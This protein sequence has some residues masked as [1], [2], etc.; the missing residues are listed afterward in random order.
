MDE[1]ATSGGIGGKRLVVND[2]GAT[3]TTKRGPQDFPLSD[4]TGLEFE[5]GGRMAGGYLLIRTAATPAQVPA[6]SKWSNVEGLIEFLPTNRAGI[7]HAA[8]ELATL[9]GVSVPGLPDAR[10]LPASGIER[11]DEKSRA[12]AV[13]RG[14][15]V[16][17]ALYVDSVLY[18]E[19]Q[20]TIVVR[21]HV[22][23]LHDHGK[24]VS[25]LRTGKGVE[26]IPIARI[27]SVE[28]KK[29]GPLFEALVIYTSGNTIQYVSGGP[30][31]A[32]LRK[33]ISDLVN[34]Q[35]APKPA[36]PTPGPPA[37]P[38]PMAQLKQL[39]ELHAQGILT[40][41]EFAAKKTDLLGRL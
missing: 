6:R 10:P 27:S 37:A 33:I 28:T 3:I 20:T 36:S 38:D 19:R 40:D 9:L 23:E 39:A 41:A 24:V 32:Q 16:D 17:D 25:L 29:L 12:K 30:V 14:I 8:R 35:T 11:R 15:N 22:V 18:D 26:E 7:A 21:P 5:P 34:G 31:V 1:Y 4:I 13:K 2:L